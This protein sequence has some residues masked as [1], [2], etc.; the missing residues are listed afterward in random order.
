MTKDLGILGPLREDKPSTAPKALGSREGDKDDREDLRNV[1]PQRENLVKK[2]LEDI[3]KSERMF[4]PVFDQMKRNMFQVKNGRDE[5]TPKSFYTANISRR[6]IHQ[7][8]SVM[9]ARNP[10]FVA[11]AKRRLYYA[12]WDGKMESLQMALANI[13]Q[14]AQAGL[15]ADPNDVALLK[16]YERGTLRKNMINKVGETAEIL[17]EYYTGEAEPNFKT[18]LKQTIKRMLTNFVGYVKVDFQRDM[19]HSP[20][21]QSQINDHRAR[22]AHLEHLADKIEKGEVNEGDAEIEEL[23]LGLKQL[24]QQEEIIL[25]EGLTYGFPTSTS[26]KVDPNCTNLNGF[27]GADWI[28]EEFHFE[29]DTASE[30][31]G[32]DFEEAGA[33]TFTLEKAIEDNYDEDISQQEFIEQEIVKVYEYYHKP[34]G[35]MY[36]VTPGFN[37]FCEEPREPNVRL[38]RFFPIYSYCP[39]SIE[40]EDS[41]YG[42]SD[43]ETMA[44][45]QNEFNKSRQG[46]SEHRRA[47]R[48]KLAYVDGSLDDE[49]VALLRNHPAF[50]VLPMKGLTSGQRIEDLL[51][52]IPTPG[53]DPNLYVTNHIVDDVEL[54]LGVQEALL[55]ATSGASATETSISQSA[56]QT[57]ISSHVDELDDFLSDIAR[58]SLE[59]MLK[60]LNLETV[61]EIVGPG[62]VWPDLPDSTIESE[63]ELGIEA[64]S[65]GKPNAA[66][67]LGKIERA[68]PLIVQV[69][70]FK[71]KKVASMILKTLDANHDI[72]DFFDEDLP[73]IVA[74][75][76]QIQ[77]STGNPATDPNAQGGAL[78]VNIPGGNQSLA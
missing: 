61:Q 63:F 64:G 11:K 51:Q 54:T 76:Q 36:T 67:E 8:T 77:P 34:T 9:Y 57:T 70:G 46:L 71:P 40:D 7:T 20:Q 26:V 48:P 38:Q 12:L 15:P 52:P 21:V 72:N 10:T 23:R 19:A 30:I 73:S 16:D 56:S 74:M 49:D 32:F 14:R 3:E 25:S 47:A 39:S 41:I 6:Y 37:N 22:L 45:M 17:M 68:T 35:L 5:H 42:P 75:N 44:P 24:E 13:Q 66:A 69:P 27:V 55:G 18:N 1:P 65:S 58:G 31:Y 28:A 59:V 78:P 60:E 33:T 4:Q 53:V 43:I 2:I 62:A 50:S 29:P